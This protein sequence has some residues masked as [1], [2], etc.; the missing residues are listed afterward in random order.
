MHI[1]KY[2]LK[3]KRKKKIIIH[4]VGWVLQFLV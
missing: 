2:D 3:K 1:T 4:N